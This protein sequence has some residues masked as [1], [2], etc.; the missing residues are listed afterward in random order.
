MLISQHQFQNALASVKI[1][2]RVSYFFAELS[3]DNHHVGCLLTEEL[4]SFVHQMRDIVS[5]ENCEF[6]VN[7]CLFYFNVLAQSKGVSSLTAESK[8]ELTVILEILT[9]ALSFSPSEP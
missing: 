7:I 4:Q 6:A 8:L 1:M 3:E 9:K 5:N 2:T